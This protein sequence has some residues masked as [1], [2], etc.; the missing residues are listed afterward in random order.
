M[1]PE[2]LAALIGVPASVIAA[3]IAYPIG[4]GVARRQAEDQHTQ[5]L[6]SQRQSTSSQLSDATTD[7]IGAATHAWEAVAR[8]EYA[9]TRRRDLE[10]R[11]R[12]DPTLYEPLR[13]AMRHMYNA[14]PAVALHGPREVTEASEQL[15]QVALEMTGAVL[16]LDAAWVQRS[17]MASAIPFDGLSPE[18]MQAVLDDLD[19]AYDRLAAPLGLPEF[20]ADAEASLRTSAVVTDMMR[21]C[22][23]L[24]DLPA[25]QAAMSDLRMSVASDPELRPYVE[26]FLSFMPVVE[27]RALARATQEGR[28]IGVDQ[29]LTA[30]SGAVPALL[31]M[32][33]SLRDAL[34]DPIPEGVDPNDLPSEVL[35]VV[36]S[37]RA[38]MQH[39]TRP[40]QLLEEM[41]QQLALR[42]ELAAP[43]AHDPLTALVASTTWDSS[44]AALGARAMEEVTQFNTTALLTADVFTPLLDFLINTAEAKVITA[45][46]RLLEARMDFIAA[47]REAIAAA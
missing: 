43:T 25:A 28:P 29:M 11:K 7:F 13:T 16:H 39:L 38:S 47:A 33:V 2:V 26:P 35:D 12:L 27:L 14:L 17:V 21:V 20:T 30:L 40:F 5:W 15:Y 1:E 22:T 19:S 10:S 8:P 9:H 41:Q 46:K 32:F 31:G 4:R 45:K 34:Q 3:A 24:D 6:R 23:A 36:Q 37:V 44:M 18:R 42:D